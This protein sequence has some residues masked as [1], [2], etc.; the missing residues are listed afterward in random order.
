[1]QE[2]R[3][4]GAVVFVGNERVGLE[5]SFEPITSVA[6]LV[7]LRGAPVAARVD[8]SRPMAFA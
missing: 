4:F 8:D 7:P 2:R 5:H 1:M 3:E 6:S